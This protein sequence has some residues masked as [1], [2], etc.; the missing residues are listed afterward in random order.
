MEKGIEHLKVHLVSYLRKH[1]EHEFT[2]VHALTF[3]TG[4][5]LTQGKRQSYQQENTRD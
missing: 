1:T 2:K 4:G 5:R 3:S